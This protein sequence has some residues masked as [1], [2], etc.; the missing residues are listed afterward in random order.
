MNHATDYDPYIHEVHHRQKVDS[1]SGT[2]LT[3]ARIL[4]DSIDRK[5]AILTAAPEG[6]IKPEMLH[7]SSTRVGTV[8][9]THTVG[10][11]SEADY[12]ELNHVARTRR[13]FA[14]GALAAAQWLRAERA[15]IQWTTWICR[16]TMTRKS[17][18][19]TGTAMITPFKADGSIDEQALRRFVDFQIDGGVDMLLP[20]GTTGEGATLDDDETDRVVRIVIEQAKGRVPI[21]VGAGSNSTAKAVQMAKRV[22]K[23]GADG[24]LSVGPYYNKPTQQGYYEHFRSIAEAENIP[25][26]VY[27]VPGRTGG[28]IEAKTM[29]RLAEIPNIVAVKEA[30][31][32]IGQIMDI[33]RDAPQNFSVLSGDD[34][35]ALPVIAV[36]GHGIVSVVSNE[37]PA[38]MSAMIHAALGG[39]L[40]QAKELHYKLLPLM[41]INFIESNPIPVK[42]ALAMM[43]LIEENYRL[44]LVRITP[45]SREKLAKVVEEVGLLQPAARA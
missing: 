41:N 31:G 21:I 2:A 40:T 14:L 23:L 5:E 32:N 38:M 15:F 12:I 42:A 3:L 33:I 22:R 10:F 7:V 1:P 39:N 8:P 6:K 11:D 45:A 4:I 17:F 9:G 20:C 19:G 28:N 24:V 18:Q 35:M 43:G 26:I 36:G 34:A 16:G 37:A 13:G 29:L 44:P 25:I 30:S 27:N